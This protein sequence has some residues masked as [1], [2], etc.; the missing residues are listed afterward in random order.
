MMVDALLL[1]L[2]CFLLLHSLFRR[3]WAL[4]VQLAVHLHRVRNLVC[5][6]LAFYLLR[7]FFLFRRFLRRWVLFEPSF[8]VRGDLALRSLEVVKTSVW[9]VSFENWLVFCEI[10]I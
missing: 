3:L 4:A 6:L 9:L 2:S 7:F 10:V 8:R 1:G 5:L